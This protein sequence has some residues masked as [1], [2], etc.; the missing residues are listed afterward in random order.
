MKKLFNKP[1]ILYKNLRNPLNEKFERE[2]FEKQ[3]EEKKMWM[4]LEKIPYFIPNLNYLDW[5]EKMI[6]VVAIPLKQE[7]CYTYEEY[8]GWPTMWKMM[9]KR[10][11]LQ[12][13]NPHLIK[14]KNAEKYNLLKKIRDERIKLGS[15]PVSTTGEFDNKNVKLVVQSALKSIMPES[16][17]PVQGVNKGKNKSEIRLLEK[18]K[19][20]DEDDRKHW[21]VYYKINITNSDVFEQIQSIFS[22]DVNDDFYWSVDVRRMVPLIV[23]N[24]MNTKWPNDWRVPREEQ[25]YVTNYIIDEDKEYEVIGVVKINIL[26]EE[27]NTG[28]SEFRIYKDDVLQEKFASRYFDI[29][30]FKPYEESLKDLEKALIH[31]NEDGKEGSVYENMRR[32]ILLSYLVRKYHQG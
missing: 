3:I 13:K 12:I 11:P 4:D 31:V 20:F 6:P 19:E 23:L 10:S 15:I 14:T 30:F 8:K 7:D 5:K 25:T 29:K 26:D 2:Q 22:A 18:Y 17:T 9:E 32:F 16:I 1:T 27:K 21:L 28:E 24:H